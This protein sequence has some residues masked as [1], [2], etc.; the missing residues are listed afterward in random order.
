M[1]TFIAVALLLVSG[2]LTT[3]A[4]EDAC[5][6]KGGTWNADDSTCL[7][8]DQ[9]DMDVNY[10]VTYVEYPFVEQTVDA[11]IEETRTEFLGFVTTPETFSVPSVATFFLSITY[12]EYQ[13]SDTIVSLVFTVAE[14]TGGAHPN[15]WYKTFTFDL[16]QEQEILLDDLFIEGSDP[17]AVISPIVQE[18]LAETLG[19]MADP[20]WIEEGTGENPENYQNFA[21]TPDELIFFFPPFQVAAY[22]AGPQQVSIPLSEISTILAP[23]FNESA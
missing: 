9:I 11:F 7:I 18:D 17:L 1:K 22:A 4:Q 15:S 2:V 5:F 16:E 6:E 13:F 19:D 12:E 21:I 20:A 3:V 23:P 8:H 10:P 14:Y